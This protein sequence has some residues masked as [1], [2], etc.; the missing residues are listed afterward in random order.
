MRGT[1]GVTVWQRNY[2]ERIIRNEPELER[3]RGYICDNPARWELDRLHP[4]QP[5]FGEAG[6]FIGREGGS[7]TRPYGGRRRGL[8]HGGTADGDA[9]D[10]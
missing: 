2:W 1:R 10:R 9:R 3:I 7:Q 4:E 8:G 5:A 6:A